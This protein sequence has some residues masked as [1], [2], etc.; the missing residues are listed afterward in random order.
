MSGCRDALE[1]FAGSSRWHPQRGVSNEQRHPPRALGS[2]QAGQAVT[3]VDSL[4]EHE[5]PMYLYRRGGQDLVGGHFIDAFYDF[6]LIVESL[7]AN[8]KFKKTAMQQAFRS[9]QTLQS[10]VVT[11]LA[12]SELKTIANS[13]PRLRAAYEGTYRG[14]TPAE[15]TDRLVELRGFLH[16]HTANASPTPSMQILRISSLVR[17]LPCDLQP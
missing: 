13:R 17:P 5:I 10:A 2:A 4:V 9:N 3:A 1:V 7:Y 14:R 11:T 8:G 15:V 16:H 6:L 12:S